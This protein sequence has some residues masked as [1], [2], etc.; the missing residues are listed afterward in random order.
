[1]KEI[2][3]QAGTAAYLGVAE[4]TLED[5]R[6]RKVGPPFARVGGRVRYQKD[7]VDRWLAGQTVSAA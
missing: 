6:Y 2:D 4:R 5:W 7:R 3:D 1:M